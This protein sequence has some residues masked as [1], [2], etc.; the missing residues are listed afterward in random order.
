[1][2]CFLL[3]IFFPSCLKGDIIVKVWLIPPARQARTSDKRCVEIKSKQC[4][5]DQK[6]DETIYRFYIDGDFSLG[7][8]RCGAVTLYDYIDGEL[9]T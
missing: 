9:T 2:F 4:R 6:G 8:L 1:M 7:R 3:L 5:N